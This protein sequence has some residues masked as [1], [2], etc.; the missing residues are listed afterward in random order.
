MRMIYWA[1]CQLL[2]FS[3]LCD[4]FH[5]SAK[6]QGEK[7][8]DLST[9][10]AVHLTGNSYNSLGFNMEKILKAELKTSLL[11]AFG[12]SGGGCIS[13]GQSY[14]TDSGRVFVKINHKP[15]VNTDRLLADNVDAYR[16]QWVCLVAYRCLLMIVNGV[17]SSFRCLSL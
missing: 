6:W 3:L 8:P 15:Q 1:G 12:S 5:L 10:F 2:F 7:D 4:N 17:F 16:E 11:K 14:E 9:W 13:Q